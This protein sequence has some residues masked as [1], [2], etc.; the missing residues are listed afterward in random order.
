M[1][2]VLRVCVTPSV[3]VCVCVNDANFNDKYIDAINIEQNISKFR[4]FL[5]YILLFHFTRAQITAHHHHTQITCTQHKFTHPCDP[6]YSGVVISFTV[7]CLLYDKPV[8]LSSNLYT[9]HMPLCLFLELIL[10]SNLNAG[11]LLFCC[12]FWWV[13]K[14]IWILLYANEAREGEHPVITVYLDSK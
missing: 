1:L 3:C 6:H 9:D 8:P 5:F 10:L 13:W 11:V 12:C 7:H 14:C 4:F 2:R